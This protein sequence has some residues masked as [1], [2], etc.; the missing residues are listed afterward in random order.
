[1]KTVEVV[2]A[3]IVNDGKILAVQKGEHK[4]DYLSSKFEFA[5]GKIEVGES[6]EDALKREIREELGLEIEVEQFLMSNTYAY[7]DF[8]LVLH[9]YLCTSDGSDLRLT[10]H[11]SFQW[12]G[13]GELDSVDWC[14]GDVG[15]VEFLKL[16]RVSV[17]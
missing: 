12:L 10:E 4:Y 7:P 5:G 14:A 1:M 3:V 15:V 17:F 8:K 9:A 13:I 16:R 11:V 2:A 6:R